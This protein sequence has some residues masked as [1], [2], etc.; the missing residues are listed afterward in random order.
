MCV[1][2]KLT[3]RERPLDVKNV[4]AKQV[5]LCAAVNTALVSISQALLSQKMELEHM[6]YCRHLS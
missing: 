4:P 5:M 2:G 3:M 1:S 6:N